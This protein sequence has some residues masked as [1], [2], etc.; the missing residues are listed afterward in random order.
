LARPLYVYVKHSALARPEVLA[1]VTF[2]LEEAGVLV[3]STGYHALT[4]E[5]YSSTLSAIRE[6]AR[7]A[8]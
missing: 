3:P 2:M 8:G 4:P 7:A 1:Y 5:E 6:A